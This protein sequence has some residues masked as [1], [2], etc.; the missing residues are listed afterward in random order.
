MR[1]F[2]TMLLATSLF[3]SY[4]CAHSLPSLNRSKPFIVT[5]NNDGTKTLYQESRGFGDVGPLAFE[6]SE[7]IRNAL[8][9]D[10]IPLME[11]VTCVTFR[12][13][14]TLSDGRN[15]EI[16]GVHCDDNTTYKMACDADIF[17]NGFDQN[18]IE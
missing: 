4:G 2:K 17:D 1:L 11:T 14:T 7:A 15:L 18:I 9:R 3:Y 8:D 12:A 6:P 13:T 10:P 5:S 16:C